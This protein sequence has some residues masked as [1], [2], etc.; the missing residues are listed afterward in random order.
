M[1][2]GT[3]YAYSLPLLF[4]IDRAVGADGLYKYFIGIMAHNLALC[5][6]VNDTSALHS[7]FFTGYGNWRF[8]GYG[9][10]SGLDSIKANIFVPRG[11]TY[12]MTANTEAVGHFQAQGGFL[13]GYPSRG[14]SSYDLLVG[15][16]NTEPAPTGTKS[17]DFLI[18]NSQGGNFNPLTLGYRRRTDFNGSEAPHFFNSISW[19]DPRTSNYP[20]FDS[21]VVF[22][23]LLNQAR[24]AT[25]TGDPQEIERQI[26]QA[27]EKVKLLK[28]VSEQYT[29]HYRLNKKYA[30]TYDQYVS[31]FNSETEKLSLDLDNLRS[32]LS[33]LENKPSICDWSGPTLSTPDPTPD[34]RSVYETK[35][36]ELNTMVALAFKADLTNSATMSLCLEVNHHNQHYISSGD[37]G[38]DGQSRQD[39][40]NHGNGL[41][42]YMD[43]V[44]KNIVH[45]VNELKRLN[46]FD[47]TLILVSG[48]QSDGNTHTATEAP[49]FVIDG[50]NATWNGRDVG[51][52]AP[53][54]QA[55]EA[56]PYS[57]L[58]VDVLGK[59]GVSRS[60]FGSPRNVK[61][62]GKG[63]IF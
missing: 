3:G 32:G 8:G 13:T 20:T 57:D 27:D 12:R 23:Q 42:D 40:I 11:L 49:V 26:S 17:I 48:E 33:H 36:K 10:L 35:V 25:Y 56:R 9:S 18:A 29:R 14:A 53:G 63:G 38:R 44:A 60:S 28:R 1:L 7:G 43:S 59:Y 47:Q 62:S 46:I 51:V 52:T 39:I 54:Q 22:N 4:D 15:N 21:K 34:D 16:S 19:V 61:G 58:L 6:T 55:P 2:K 45:L 31:G 37:I 24:C 50:K 41:R 5:K 30:E